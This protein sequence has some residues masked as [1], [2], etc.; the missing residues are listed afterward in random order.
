MD[1]AYDLIDEIEIMIEEFEIEEL[2]QQQTQEEKAGLEVKQN[3]IYLVELQS[4]ADERALMNLID[5]M[6]V[7]SD[8]ERNSKDDVALVLSYLPQI[9]ESLQ[10]QTKSWNMFKS[11]EL[12]KDKVTSL[13]TKE[14]DIRRHVN[15]C[16]VLAFI[17][18]TYPQIVNAKRH[19][20]TSSTGCPKKNAPT[21]QSHIYKSIK[22][23]VFKFS[24]VI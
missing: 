4:V 2:A 5:D 7:V 21:L 24:T 6:L 11:L 20:S 9:E 12:S 22:F 23:E 1:N 15:D 14:G 13:F 17:K 10:N 19:S 16:T 18:K 3:E 8:E